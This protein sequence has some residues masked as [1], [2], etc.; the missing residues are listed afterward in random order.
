MQKG[1][2]ITRWSF[3][4]EDMTTTHVLFPITMTLGLFLL[5]R[6]ITLERIAI[7]FLFVDLKTIKLI[8]IVKL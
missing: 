3:L 7:I 2:I 6:G 8:I 1:I 5:F 4:E